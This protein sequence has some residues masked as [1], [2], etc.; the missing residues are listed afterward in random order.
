MAA[1]IKE[2]LSR[3]RPVNNTIKTT[4]DLSLPPGLG[5]AFN[6]PGNG[7]DLTYLGSDPDEIGTHSLRKGAATYVCPNRTP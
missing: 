4:N 3:V 2:E 6:T 5:Y 1:I 7:E